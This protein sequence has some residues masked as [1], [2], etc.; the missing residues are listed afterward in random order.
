MNIKEELLAGRAVAKR[1]KN[2]K[3]M[4]FSFI[5]PILF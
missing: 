1:R 5:F 4:V 3:Q 2:D